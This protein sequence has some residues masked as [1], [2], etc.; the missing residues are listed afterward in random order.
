MYS[1]SKDKLELRHSCDFDVIPSFLATFNLIL[2]IIYTPMQAPTQSCTCT[3]AK[4]RRC[5]G[6][7]VMLI[8]LCSFTAF[9]SVLWDLVSYSIWCST[10]GW[11]NWPMSFREPPDS[12]SPKLDYRIQPFD[13]ALM[14]IWRNWT[15]VLMFATT[16]NTSLIDPPSQW[17]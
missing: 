13:L 17:P 1:K 10:I 4:V 7:R 9:H 8:I 12:A 3:Q 11:N 6:K 2:L 14:W 15:W 16:A 5:L